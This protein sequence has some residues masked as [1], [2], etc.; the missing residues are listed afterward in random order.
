[1][2]LINYAARDVTAFYTSLIKS[3]Q[4]LSHDNCNC[5]LIKECLKFPEKAAAYYNKML[6]VFQQKRV[7]V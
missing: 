3:V 6:R 2:I 7:M 5:V 4:F 1:L